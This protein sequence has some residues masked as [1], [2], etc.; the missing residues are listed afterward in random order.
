MPDKVLV[1]GITGFIAKHVAREFLEA[2]YSVRG[3]VRS[4][5]KGRTVGETLKPHGEVE[6]VEADLNSDAGWEAAVDGCNCVAHVASPFPLGQPRHEEELIRPAVDGTLRVLRAA[7]RAGARRFVL[8]S[9]SAAVLAGQPADRAVFTE[10]DWAHL[11]SPA[12]GAYAK[13]KTLAERA[14]RE[15]VG[16][17]GTKMHFATVNP[18]FVLGPPLDATIGSSLSVIQ[19]LLDGKYPGCPRLCFPSVDV[20]DVAKAHRLAMETQEP[21]GGRYVAVGDSA[22]LVELARALKA[23]LGEKARR[24]P[25]GELP[26]FVVRLVAL[27]DPAVR[28]VLSEIGIERR[29]DNSRTRKA[30]G[31]T[32]RPSTEAAVDAGR[33]LIEMGLTKA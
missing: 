4:L 25:R 3:T 7:G 24:V 20:R 28:G 5:R 30:L 9:S 11:D 22:W 6:L 29:I 10:D 26:Y 23:A 31:M 13:S 12:T 21:S 1:T 2:G 16:E 15:F 33:R 27:F 14:A 32:F 17:V 19:M 8:T 18:G